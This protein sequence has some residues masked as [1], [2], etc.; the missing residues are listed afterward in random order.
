MGGVWDVC[1][2]DMGYLWDVYGMYMGCT[3]IYI[4]IYMGCIWDLVGLMGVLF[5]VYCDLMGFHQLQNCR[6]G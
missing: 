5:I 2:M 1:G 4:Y 3:Y 6:L